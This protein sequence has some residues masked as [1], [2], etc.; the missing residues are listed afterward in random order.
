M[1][2][3]MIVED[4]DTMIS[5]L[6]TL[7]KL[8]GYQVLTVL[9]KSGNVIDNVRREIPD[10]LVLDVFLGD[11]NGL[12]II[13]A[14][15]SENDLKQIHVIMTSGIDM[16]EKCMQAGADDFLLKPYMPDEL[17]ARLMDEY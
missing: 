10:S 11:Q 17:I 13:H 3:V 6:T 5:L 1:K 8:E 12:D 15:R 2:K 14:L 4:D 16:R 7:L 9:D